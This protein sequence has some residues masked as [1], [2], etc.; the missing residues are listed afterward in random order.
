[1]LVLELKHFVCLIFI[2]ESVVTL[3]DGAMGANNSNNVDNYERDVMLNTFKNI[4][5]LIV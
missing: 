4:I 1:V 3:E 5:V 2:I